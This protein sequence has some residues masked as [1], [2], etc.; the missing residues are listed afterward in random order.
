MTPYRKSSP[1]LLHLENAITRDISFKRFLVKW[2]NKPRK[3][4]APL[5]QLQVL[6]TVSFVNFFIIWLR[7]MTHADWLISGLKKVILPAQESHLALSR[8]LSCPLV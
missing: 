6:Y 7:L 4:P 3:L 5:S 2:N 8:N 1:T